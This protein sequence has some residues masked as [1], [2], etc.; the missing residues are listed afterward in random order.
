MHKRKH[1]PESEEKLE[2][3]TEK[4]KELYDE[5]FALG[6]RDLAGL[7]ALHLSQEAR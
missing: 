5:L 2:A 3:F 1:Q 4:L 6:G 7:A